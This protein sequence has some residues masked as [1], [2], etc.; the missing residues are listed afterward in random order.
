MR[1]RVEKGGDRVAGGV[2]GMVS[3]CE[4]VSYTGRRLVAVNKAQQL[5]Q[6]L[7]ATGD[8][9]QQLTAVIEMCQVGPL[10]IVFIIENPP[11]SLSLS[12]AIVILSRPQH[13]ER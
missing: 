11:L 12:F 4:C 3:V 5:L 6:G 1:P 13:A 2:P 9:G 7:Q 10:Y 8:E